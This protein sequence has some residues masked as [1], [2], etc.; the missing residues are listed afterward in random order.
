MYSFVASKAQRLSIVRPGRGA[1]VALFIAPLLVARP[2]A[3]QAAS[4]AVVVAE[5]QTIRVLAPTLPSADRRLTGVFLGID[6]TAGGQTLRL[7]TE[8]GT[9][10][11]PCTLVQTV[12]TPT[13]RHIP[14]WQKAGWALLGAWGGLALA[15]TVADAPGGIDAEDPPVP[16]PERDAA[17]HRRANRILISGSLAGAGIAYL[18]T[19]DSD[20]WH[21][22][23]LAGCNG[24]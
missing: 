6:T 14:L 2:I 24:S 21:S 11:V 5:G 16:H 7:R 17:A 9:Q 12:Q 1:V 3:A 8:R 22:A 13:V 18:V 23:S 4:P 15:H 20:R 19:R 10:F